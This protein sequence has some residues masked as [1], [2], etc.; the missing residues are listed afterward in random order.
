MASPKRDRTRLLLGFTARD[1]TALK[2]SPARR[3]ALKGLGLVVDEGGLGKPPGAVQHTWRHLWVRDARRR[4]ISDQRMAALSATLGSSLSWTA[5]VVRT[6][7]ARGGELGAFLPDSL[8]VAARPGADRDRVARVLSA[9][10]WS[11]D[12]RKSRYLGRWRFFTADNPGW[13]NAAEVAALLREKQG[14]LV[15]EVRVEFLGHASA[16]QFDPN[17]PFYSRQWALPRI[18]APRAWDIAK[19]AGVVVAIIDSGCDLVHPQLRFAGPGINLDTGAG[20]A[21]PVYPIV[22]PDEA[23][24]A[25]GTGVAGV[26]GARLNDFNGIAGLAGECTL[27]PLATSTFTNAAIAM[28]VRYAWENGARVINMSFEVTGW[29]FEGSPLQ[30]A[31]EDA[32]A[33]GIV[34]CG[35]SGNGNARHLI[36]PARHPAVIACGASNN[37]DRRWEE[38]PMPS[39]P[40]QGSNYE[41]TVFLGQPVGVAVVAPGRDILTTDISGTGGVTRFPSPSGDQMFFNATSAAT[42]HVSA[43]AALLL[44]RYPTI[45]ADAAAIRRIIKRTADKVGGYAYADVPGY[46]EGSRHPEMGFG[47]LNAFRALDLGDVM[48]ADWPGDDGIEPST[49]PGGDFWSSSDLVIRPGDDGIF[50]PADPLLASVLV[51]GRDHTVTMRV[52][53]LG[54]ADARNVHVEARITP[55]V[56]LE[57]A[58]PSDWTE[59]NPLHLRLA[60]VLAD[61]DLLSANP[62]ENTAIARFTL[63]AA[64]ADIAAG[65]GPMGWHPCALGV[66]TSDND[67]AFQSSAAGSRLQLLR[68]NLVQRNLTVMSGPATRS[69]RFS[70]VV[71]HPASPDRTI[72][73]VVE[74]G[75]AALD[76]K[77]QLVIDDD[78][79][80]F[81]VLKRAQG[82]AAGRLLVGKIAGGKLSTIGKR[83]VVTL[84]RSRLSVQLTAPR[85]GRFAVHLALTLPRDAKPNERFTLSVAQ[86]SQRRG[87]VGGA[88]FVYVVEK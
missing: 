86:R 14:D 79:A 53:N 20:D 38:P 2:L 78:G 15:A 67:Y 85:A 58:H 3:A 56:G 49:P 43:V 73:L 19:G 88:K 54:P 4:A 46:P 23:K 42:P 6:P 16:L 77:V 64:Q 1:G 13:R 69:L 83:R 5:S 52:R 7:G 37:T 80:A 71:G 81:P 75:R 34:L 76:G 30:E 62:G 29:E 32:A 40:R 57:F 84:E 18:D 10:G 70:F 47:R 66:V 68:N 51:R 44:S 36:T 55:W 41:D 61:F 63:T 82:F 25:H 31:I 33:A 48:I 65:W 27:L 50:E 17:D 26:I 60:P 39:R 24:L 87:T 22:L 21:S 74:T 11:E 45:A 35:A 59:D 28:G 12:A 8:L 72:E 9:E